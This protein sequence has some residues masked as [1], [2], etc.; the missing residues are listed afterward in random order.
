MPV[1]KVVNKGKPMNQPQIKY[2]PVKSCIGINDKFIK[3]GVDCLEEKL[4]DG[5]QMEF[6]GCY[7]VLYNN[8]LEVIAS[9]E[10]LRDMIVNLVLTDR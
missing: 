2:T 1:M 10:T 8:E 3:P 9:G 6:D 7:W 5:C 4:N